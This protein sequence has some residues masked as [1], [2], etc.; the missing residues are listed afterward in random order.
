MIEQ[1]ITFPSI[2]AALNISCARRRLWAAAR[3]A[4]EVGRARSREADGDAK[5]SLAS[6]LEEKID[7]ASYERAFRDDPQR[8]IRPGEG[9]EEPTGDSSSD[10][11]WLVEIG[12]CSKNHL[13][14]PPAR[15]GKLTGY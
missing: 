14:S 3:A 6:K 13:P 9:F 10:F 12:S 1:S 11:D 7:I 15:S 2:L 8:S 5:V 4:R